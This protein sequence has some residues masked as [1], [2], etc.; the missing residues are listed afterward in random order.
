MN[1]KKRIAAAAIAGL[2]FSTA[3]HSSGV[4]VVDALANVT[5]IN[6][7]TQK[8][9]QWTDTVQHYK[10]QMNAYKQQLA[11]ATGLRDI[12]GFISQAR[13]MASDLKSL[14]KRGISLDDLLTNPGGS[15]TSE[16]NSLYRKYQVFD[17]CNDSA[18]GDYLDSCKKIVLNQ[19]AAIEDTS[20]VQKK[21]S[22]ALS[23]ISELSNRI[24]YS[25]DSKESQDL[26]NVVSAKSIQL[27]AL[28]TQWEMSVKQAEQRS[29][30]LEVQKHKAFAKQQL[31]A[32]VADLNNIGR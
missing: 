32:P 24:Q 4:P 19:A 20:D 29:K 1:V 17:S 9:T 5:S 2:L 22:E 30:M 8:L 13:N 6:Q 23:D 25:Q 31:N 10:E 15:Y 18:T 26:A 12:Q 7:W 16:L 3:V 11:T 27:N 14:Q 28:T 21:I